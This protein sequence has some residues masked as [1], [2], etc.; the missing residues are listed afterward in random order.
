MSRRLTHAD[1]LASWRA[2]GEL[3]GHTVQQ[4][5]SFVNAL[6]DVDD[7]RSPLPMGLISPDGI[8]PRW[9]GRLRRIFGRGG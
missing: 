1:A 7:E 9:L 3:H 5:L 8:E 4:T 2:D 6:Q